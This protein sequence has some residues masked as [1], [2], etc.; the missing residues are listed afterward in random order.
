M[1]LTIGAE[2]LSVPRPIPCD[3]KRD[4]SLKDCRMF[5]LDPRPHSIGF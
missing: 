1:N 5:G 4:D 2:I 3:I